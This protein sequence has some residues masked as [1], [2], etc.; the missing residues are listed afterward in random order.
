MITTRGKEHIKR[1]FAEYE[2][3]IASTIAFG[4]SDNAAALGDLRM[5]F[6]AGRTDILVKS[7][8]FVNDKLVLKAAIPEFFQGTIYELGVFANVLPDNTEST[9]VLAQFDSVEEN[10]I[11]TATTLAMPFVSTGVRLGTDGVSMTPATSATM[12][13][14]WPEISMDL[15]D[16]TGQDEFAFYLNVTNTNTTSVAVQF[17]TD[18]SNY[19]SFTW[20]TPVQTSG[21]KKLTATKATMTATGTPTWSNITEIRVVVVSKATGASAVVLDG[22]RIN[23]VDALNPSSILVARSV[24]SVPFTKTSGKVQEIEYNLDID[25]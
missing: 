25:I 12:T 7:Y 13:A 1:Y 2:P 9:R 19:Y 6:E 3:T 5:G 10:W 11:N 4:I 18:T 14:S 22:I 20:T 15:S 17:L 24:L 8:D 23:D 16:F 21:Y